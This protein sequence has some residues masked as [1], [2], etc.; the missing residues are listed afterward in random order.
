MDAIFSSETSV[1]T[2][3]TRHN[4]P[5]DGILHNHRRENLKS[6]YTE[7][8]GADIAGNSYLID[9]LILTAWESSYIFTGLYNWATIYFIPVYY[10]TGCS[11]GQY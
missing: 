2:R 11:F 1:L 9:S 5:E 8:I 7:Y 6:Y 4:I 10:E 3:A